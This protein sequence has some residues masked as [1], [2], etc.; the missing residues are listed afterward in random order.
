MIEVE[1]VREKLENNLLKLEGVSGVSHR[2][3]EIILY[4]ESEEHA[5]AVP[6]V[7]AGIPVRKVVVGRIVAFRQELMVDRKSRVRPV[8]GG[9]SLGDPSVTAGTLSC[10]TANNKIVSNAHVI[11][12]NHT[13]R[14]WNDPCTP[15]LQPGPYD[16]GKAEDRIGC[17]EKYVPIK[18]NDAE[19]ENYADAA[20]G[21]IDDPRL[22]KPLTVLG[23]DNTEYGIGGTAEVRVGDI[24]RKSGRTTGWTENEVMDTNATVKVYGYP[25]GWA[26]FRDQILVRQYFGAGGDSGSLV[27]DEGGRVVGLLFAGSPQVIVVCKVKHFT[28]YLGLDFG[29]AIPPDYLTMGGIAM[30]VIAISAFAA[31][32]HEQGWYRLPWE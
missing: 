24:V 17:L 19:A 32:A 5:R 7:L 3:P 25:M 2:N 15:I 9:I 16:G 11:A 6:S 13:Q 22:G 27:F 23:K 29:R 1:A 26:V 10:I 21:S 8:L 14:K 28:D 30:A 20:C 12:I 4:V 18:F 31:W